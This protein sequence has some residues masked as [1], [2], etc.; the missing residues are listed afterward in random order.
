MQVAHH[1]AR[2]DKLRTYPAAAAVDYSA[3]PT[4]VLIAY[5]ALNVHKNTV[6]GEIWCSFLSTCAFLIGNGQTYA[7]L[8]VPY[9]RISRIFMSRIFHPCNMVPHFHVPQVHVSH[10][11]RPRW[12][13]W[14][15]FPGGELGTVL[16]VEYR[17]DIQPVK[18]C[19]TYPKRFS[20]RTGR[21]EL[22]WLTL[23]YPESSC[24]SG[25]VGVATPC[26]ESWAG[27]LVC[28]K[29]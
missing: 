29:T 7:T 25:G 24:W 4:N 8:G 13:Y 18:T 21:R 10:F 9:Y 20:L 11:Q 23:V 2:W 12:D 28:K 5:R 6:S 16:F 27:F 3:W 22:N 15:A 14:L 1:V 17:K 26:T 19:A